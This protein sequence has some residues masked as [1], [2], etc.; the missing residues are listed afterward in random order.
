MSDTNASYNTEE[1][2]CGATPAMT[3]KL[4]SFVPNHSNSDPPLTIEYEKSMYPPI[5]YERKSSRNAFLGYNAD[6]VFG[7]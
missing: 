3:D 2:K 1:A 5:W 7:K 4:F 6:E